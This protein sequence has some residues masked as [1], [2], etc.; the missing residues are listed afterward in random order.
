MGTADDMSSFQSQSTTPA[1]TINLDDDS[2]QYDHEHT[3]R[4][5]TIPSAV[6]NEKLDDRASRRSSITRA[7]DVEKDADV[8]AQASQDS[9]DPEKAKEQEQAPKNPA[10][11]EKDPNLVQWNGP[12]DPENPQNLSVGKKWLI[13]M[14]LS[15]LTVWITF[16]TSVF[17]QATEVTA[18]EYGVSDEVMIL[19]TSLPLFVSL[20]AFSLSH[21]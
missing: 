5:E 8:E 14:L 1:G 13:T 7:E 2:R 6:P 17:S 3:G 9:T 20:V 19:A 18:L 16:S 4:L 15:S 12:E 10:A 11:A 21:S